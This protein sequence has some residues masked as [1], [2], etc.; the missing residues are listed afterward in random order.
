MGVKAAKSPTGPLTY[1]N[2]IELRHD[3]SFRFFL[4]SLFYHIF[5]E[6]KMRQDRKMGK[7]GIM[8]L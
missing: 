3:F 1:G 4:I 2:I 7:N 8:V 6:F 5:A